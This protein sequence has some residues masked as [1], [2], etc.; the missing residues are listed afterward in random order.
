MTSTGR[1]SELERAFELARTGEYLNT[2][3]IRDQVRKEGFSGTQIE[4]ASL[5]NQLNEICRKAGSALVVP[6]AGE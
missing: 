5:R 3:Q 2:S 4:G 6:H 1:P